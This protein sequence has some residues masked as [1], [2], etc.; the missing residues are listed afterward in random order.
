[1]AQNNNNDKTIIQR[2]YSFFKDLYEKYDYALFPFYILIVIGIIFYN[3]LFD[4]YDI[5]KNMPLLFLFSWIII[6][7]FSFI[8]YTIL[9]TKD[10]NIEDIPYYG[11]ESIYGIIYLF[12]M[13]FVFCLLYSISK[14]LLSNS[15]TKSVFIATIVIVLLLALGYSLTKDESDVNNTRGNTFFYTIINILLL[16]PCYLVYFYE[17]IVKDVKQ[18]P[19]STVTILILIVL[20]LF[21]Y[22][23]IPYLQKINLNNSDG[24]VL[25]K[26]ATHLGTEVLYIPQEELKKK[27]IENRSFIEKRILTMNRRFEKQLAHSKPDDYTTISLNNMTSNMRIETENGKFVTIKDLPDCMGETVSCNEKGHVE[28]NSSEITNYLGETVNCQETFYRQLFNKESFVSHHNPEIHKLDKNIEEYGFMN[29]LTPEEQKIIEKALENKNNNLSDQIKKGNNPKDTEM[30]VLQY[31]TNSDAYSDIMSNIYD[32]N[33]ENNETL[34]QE[35]SNLIKMINRMYKI[36]DYNYHYALSFWVYFDPEM[37]KQDSGVGKGMIMNY[38]YAPYIY[39]DF[40]TQELIVEINDCKKDMMIKCD[41]R[42]IVYR[43][44]DVVFQ[45]WVNFVVNYNYGT[46]DLFVDTNLVLTQKNVAPYIQNRDNYIQFGSNEEPLKHS[47][48][49]HVVYYPVPLKLREIKNLYNNKPCH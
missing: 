10:L 11:F 25:L 14:H 27:Q 28:C 12:L 45:K 32:L 49:C 13:F 4:P 37:L 31:L 46:L 21:V 24:L 18:A 5:V 48:I 47:G 35:T 19:S 43:S 9:K 34:R 38:A 1:M 8:I 2:L 7:F 23:I 39:Y 36:N 30:L 6:L 40:K 16:I 33:L 26:K 15:T 22:Y 3:Y 42:D 29:Y 41:E 17:F 20:I 44:K